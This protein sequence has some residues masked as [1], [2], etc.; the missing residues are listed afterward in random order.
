MEIK[1]DICVIGAGPAGIAAAIAAST[2]NIGT[3]EE[4]NKRRKVLLVDSN[5]E[6]GKKLLMTG[7][8][9]CNFA[10]DGLEARSRALE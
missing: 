4:G 5:A 9:R 7:N 6:I 2:E 8:G 3:F 1:T 10:H